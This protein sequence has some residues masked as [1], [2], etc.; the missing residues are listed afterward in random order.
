MDTIAKS[1]SCTEMSSW[2][3]I[4][5]SFSVAVVAGLKKDKMSISS[6]HGLKKECIYK[7]VYSSFSPG[8]RYESGRI[9]RY[10]DPENIMDPDL[11]SHG[12]FFFLEF[13][14]LQYHKEPEPVP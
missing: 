5:S 13:A 7:I 9:L 12:S 8:G 14:R 3:G 2:I 4:G 11:V 1:V 10:S 6:H